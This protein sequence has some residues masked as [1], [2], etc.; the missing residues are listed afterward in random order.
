[1]WGSDYP[2]GDG[3]CARIVEGHRR[4]VRPLTA[5]LG[6]PAGALPSSQ[7]TYQ[8]RRRGGL[9]ARLP[10]THRYRVT[11]EGLRAGLFFT[12]VHARLFRPGLAAAPRAG[13]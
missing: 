2:H 10:G 12:R 13:R 1:M 4:A 8:L 3:F 7:M 5:L 9:I 11:T 6:V